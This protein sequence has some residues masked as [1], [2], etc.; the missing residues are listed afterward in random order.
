M[1]KEVYHKHSSNV[2]RNKPLTHSEWSSTTAHRVD[3]GATGD[4]IYLESSTGGFVGLGIGTSGQFLTVSSS[5][6]PEW[7]STITTDRIFED[8][9]DIELGT[10]SDAIMRFSTGDSDNRCG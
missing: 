1:A 2:E 3:G 5:G 10:G 4:M 9:I 7:S 6:L 8:D